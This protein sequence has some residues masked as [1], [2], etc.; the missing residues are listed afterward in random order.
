M[1]NL[2]NTNAERVTAWRKAHPGE[3]PY[4]VIERLTDEKATLLFKRYED[5]T[6]NDRAR[7]SQIRTA[8]E[9]TWDMKRLWDAEHYQ[10]P[11]HAWTQ[12]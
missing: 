2:P 5:I 4:Q 11:H 1:N 3:T 12:Q 10:T 9:S 6:D 7:I 8:L